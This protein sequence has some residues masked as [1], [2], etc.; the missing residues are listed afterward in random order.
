[1]IK[2]FI[3][4]TTRVLANVTPILIFF[5]FAQVLNVTELGLINYFISLITIIGIFTD[6][7]I[8]E[9]VQRFLPQSKNKQSLVTHTILLE[10]IIVLLGAVIFFLANLFFQI[11]LAKGYLPLLILIIIFSASNTIILIF[12]GLNREKFLTK[13][14]ALSSI[15]FAST[16]FLLYFFLGIGPIYAFLLGRLISWIMLTILPLY[17]LIKENLIKFSKG[18]QYKT[19]R[20]NK[21]AINTF[22]YLGSITLLT[23]WDS[24]WITHVDG[25]HVNGIYK[26][27]VFIATIPIALVT[28]IHTKLLPFFSNLAG[29]KKYT[30]I[31]KNLKKY[32][33][34][35]LLILVPAGIIQLLIHRPFLNIFLREEIVAE[36]GHVFPIVFFAICAYILSAPYIC[37]LQ[38]IGK[39]KT[40]RNLSLLQLFIFIVIS[41]IFYSSLG[42][43]V[44]PILLLA[45]NLTFLTLTSLSSYLNLN[46]LENRYFQKPKYDLIS[47]SHFFYPIKGGLE[48]M[49]YNMLTFLAENEYKAI[50][51]HGGGDNNKIYEKNGFDIRVFKTKNILNNA[52][53]L[54]GLAF[55]VYIKKLL[56]QNPNAKVL[57]HCRHVTSSFLSALICSILG[58][59]F[60]LLEHT[61]ETS[62][63]KGKISQLAVWIYESIFSKYVITRA[64]RIIS[65]SEASRDYLKRRYSIPAQ[66]ITVIHNGI[67]IDE[68][69]KYND[70]EKE[71]IVVFAGKFLKVKDPQTTYEAFKILAP[72]YPKWKFYFIGDGEELQAPEKSFS[73]LKFI[74][75]MIER[76]ELLKIFAK[77]KI[78]INSS[79]SEA[80]SL[81]IVEATLFG[82]IPVLSDAPSNTQIAQKLETKSFIFPRRNSV[83]LAEK[84]ELAITHSVK[85]NIFREISKKTKE[86]FDNRKFF[87]KYS[88]TFFDK[89]RTFEQ[90]NKILD[91]EK[92]LL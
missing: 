22:A 64:N 16:T 4:G 49:S 2:Q 92:P 42:Y 7:G 54:F 15:V 19:R 87:E 76:E 62:F 45:L 21:F 86:N 6:F 73:N 29:Q 79:L 31:M 33:M 59:E 26:S 63:V 72:K 11:D 17:T 43:I 14:F 56:Q 47:I 1:M 66:K 61:A 48:N 85:K 24:I 71:N 55:I 78:Y 65:V 70:I 34:Y 81:T 23:Q 9:T 8:P 37:A 88:I 38:A 52:Y 30:E 83:E 51:V 32:S 60:Y 18:R 90:E 84:I 10:F 75:R 12:N 89:T 57:I 82:N 28:V 91:K 13:Y 46:I 39:E 74:N 5:V 41:T 69:K 27:V 25:P 44:F 58:R 50:A 80:L 67:N 3:P 20:F 77:S 36:A 53:P 68:F 35:L 40:I